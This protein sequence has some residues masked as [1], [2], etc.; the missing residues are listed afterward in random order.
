MI[1]PFNDGPDKDF[2]RSLVYDEDKDNSGPQV[3]MDAKKVKPR[4]KRIRTKSVAEDWKKAPEKG[5]AQETGSRKM[6]ERQMSISSDISLRSDEDLTDL[7]MNTNQD[8][9][10]VSKH[11]EIDVD[12]SMVGYIVDML[13]I[14]HTF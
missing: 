3:A 9:E 10:S 7:V 1:T 2:L 13:N 5:S 6:S 12:N 14:Y 11:L 8:G 4:K